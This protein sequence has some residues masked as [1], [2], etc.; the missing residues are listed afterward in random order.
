MHIYNFTMTENLMKK[1]VTYKS[2]LELHEIQESG[3]AGYDDNYSPE[4][5]DYSKLTNQELEK[6]CGRMYHVRT[7]N[8]AILVAINDLRL[9]DKLSNRQIAIMA[10]YDKERSGV[11][12]NKTVK[13]KQFQ[14]RLELHKR[15]IKSIMD[16]NG[17]NITKEKILADTEEIIQK[18][19]ENK[20]YREA[21]EAVK[22]Q[23]MLC[24]LDPSTKPVQD[25]RQQMI[26]QIGDQVGEQEDKPLKSLNDLTSRLL[27]RQA[28][29]IEFK[30]DG[31]K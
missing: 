27:E 14:A 10:G 7:H 23:A 12:Y 16:E 3:I 17:I 21:L 31:D 30:V 22:Y 25:N 2:D 5:E 13:G 11:F 1:K 18:S 8:L 15:L 19:K 29:Q 20:K 4:N 6:L 28:P 26:I 9:K 24:D